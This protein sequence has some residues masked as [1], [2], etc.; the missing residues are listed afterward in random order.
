MVCQNLVGNESESISIIVLNTKISNNTETKQALIDHDTLCL[1]SIGFL[2][3]TLVVSIAVV[4]LV[5]IIV[6]RAIRK[7]NLQQRNQAIAMD[8]QIIESIYEDVDSIPSIT[9]SIR[10]NVAYGQ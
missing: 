4:M 8:T 10:H 5:I 2:A 7:S 3:G 1:A 9:L 6:S